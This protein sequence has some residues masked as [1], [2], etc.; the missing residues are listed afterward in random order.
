MCILPNISSQD[1]EELKQKR[2]S[3]VEKSSSEMVKL[4]MSELLLEDSV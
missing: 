1:L 4:I 2:I 3:E